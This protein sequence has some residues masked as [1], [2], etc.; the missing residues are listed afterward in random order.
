MASRGGGMVGIWF[1]SEAWEE[2]GGGGGGAVKAFVLTSGLKT[3]CS[4]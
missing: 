3:L 4:S 2:G 1:Q